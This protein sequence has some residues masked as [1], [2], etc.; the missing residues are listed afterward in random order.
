MSSY[1]MLAHRLCD[2]H[3]HRRRLLRYGDV[4]MPFVDSN[5]LHS[6]VNFP[7]THRHDELRWNP[8]LET[9]LTSSSLECSV[10]ARPRMP[11]VAR[12]TPSLHLTPHHRPAVLARNLQSSNSQARL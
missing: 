5:C 12:C 9:K 11:L 2:C 3:R 8:A 6:S 7:L 4:T 1:R 10:E